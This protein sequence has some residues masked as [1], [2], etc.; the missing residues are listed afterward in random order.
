MRRN[1]ARRARDIDWPGEPGAEHTASV[2]RVILF[3]FVL[4]E[5]TV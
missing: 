3:A 5:I 1:D 4:I 2:P